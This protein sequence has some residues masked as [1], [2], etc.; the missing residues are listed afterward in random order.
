[1]HGL[2]VLCTVLVQYSKCIFSYTHS[3]YYSNYYI[4]QDAWV[5]QKWRTVFQFTI[6]N[7]HTHTNTHRTQTTIDIRMNACF[8]SD[9]HCLS[10]LSPVY[11]PQYAHHVIH[12]LPKTS[13]CTHGSPLMHTVRV[14]NHKWIFH[15]QTPHNTQ[16]TI[17]TRGS[18]VMQSFRFHYPNIIFHINT[19]HNMQIIREIGM[20]ALL[21]MN[22]TV[23]AHNTK[24]IYPQ[25][26]TIF[27]QQ[28]S[29]CVDGSRVM[30]TVRVHNHK[31]IFQIHSPN[32][33]CAVDVRMRA[34]FT[35]HP[36][37]S[38]PHSQVYIVT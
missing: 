22:V 32:T 10:P 3:T 5:V 7:I 15:K 23:R 1:M 12:K 18:Q 31:G 17:A 34:W 4:H 36:H 2:Q 28:T 6:P 27:R 30:H 24:G 14:H 8:T 35:S 37:C 11:I 25:M 38:R 9:V 29:G 16:T 33:Q 19:P 26:N 13:G 21:T 20:H